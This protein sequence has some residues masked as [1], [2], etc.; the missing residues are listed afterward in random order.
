MICLEIG[1]RDVT[2]ARETGEQAERWRSAKGAAVHVH[3]FKN[4]VAKF[5]EEG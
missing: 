2:I 3:L 1:Y 4:L 5:F